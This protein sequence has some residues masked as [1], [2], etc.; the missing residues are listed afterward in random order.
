M[1]KKCF[2]ILAIDC[3]RETL[4]RSM[5]RLFCKAFQISADWNLIE[6]CPNFSV[7]TGG[8]FKRHL[9]DPL[10]WYWCMSDIVAK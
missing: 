2:L 10:V 5:V 3:E 9:A 1:L 7:L 4:E 8:R 6:V